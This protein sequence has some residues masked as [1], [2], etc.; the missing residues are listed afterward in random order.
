MHARD[1]ESY[2]ENF[3][4]MLYNLC[5]PYIF[6][7]FYFTLFEDQFPG[8]T[9]NYVNRYTMTPPLP[10]QSVRLAPSANSNAGRCIRTQLEGCVTTVTAGEEVTDGKSKLEILCHITL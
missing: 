8:K 9:G 6:L 4:V 2:L 7:K 10:A 1:S 5:H 3:M